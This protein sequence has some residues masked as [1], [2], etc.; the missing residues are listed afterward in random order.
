M[1]L[2]VKNDDNKTI[3]AIVNI[4][5][6]IAL[7]FDE[8]HGHPN[9]FEF[10]SIEDAKHLMSQ[11]KDCISYYKIEDIEYSTPHEPIK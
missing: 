5:G 11:L 10:D 4:H 2:V 8:E 9:V 6:K 3:E 7:K 1:S